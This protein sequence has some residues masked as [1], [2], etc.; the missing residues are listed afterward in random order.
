ELV[1]SLYVDKEYRKCGI[2]T[3]LMRALITIA[4]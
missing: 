1:T 2:G 4:K 3:S